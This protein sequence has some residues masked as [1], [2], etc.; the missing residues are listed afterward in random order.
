MTKTKSKTKKRSTAKT[1]V[2]K[3]KPA[4]GILCPSCRFEMRVYRTKKL[5]GEI[6]RERIC[7]RCGERQDTEELIIEE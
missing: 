5:T 1:K 4:Q 3:A 6:A 2:V 7:D